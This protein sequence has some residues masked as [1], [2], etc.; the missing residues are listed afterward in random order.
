M[1]DLLIRVVM[2]IIGERRTPKADDALVAGRQTEQAGERTG[3]DS[4]SAPAS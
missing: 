4:R 1:A 2:V 3:S